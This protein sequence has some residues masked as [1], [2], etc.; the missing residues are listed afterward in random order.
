MTAVDVLCEKLEDLHRQGKLPQ[1]DFF[2]AAM[3]FVATFFYAFMGKH[4]VKVEGIDMEKLFENASEILLR[5]I[6]QS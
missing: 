2:T 3:M 1:G 4:R 6:Q 5:G